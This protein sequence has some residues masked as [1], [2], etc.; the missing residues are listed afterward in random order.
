MKRIS[1]IIIILI[2]IF[3]IVR[4][5]TSIYTLWHKQDL[6][7]NAQEQL[8]QEKQE[9]IS[10][11]QEFAKVKSP[12]YVDEQARDKLLLMK[13]GENQV[14]I[15]SSLLQASNSAQ[16][17]ESAKPYWQQWIDLFFDF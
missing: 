11:H 10:L 6:L 2:L 7:T 8:R 1:F 14:L 3:I 9:N 5:A 15:D 13:P 4:L 12:Q 16:K 17:R